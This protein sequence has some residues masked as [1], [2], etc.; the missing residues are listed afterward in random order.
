MSTDTDQ[1]SSSWLADSDKTVRY[2][3]NAEQDSRYKNQIILQLG[4]TGNQ[5]KASLY[6]KNKYQPDFSR[7][8]RLEPDGTLI[9][10]ETGN[11]INLKTL[12]TNFL[13]DDTRLII[14]GH[15]RKV[16]DQKTGSDKFVLTGK[17]VEQLADVLKRVTGGRFVHTISVLG[18]GTNAIGEHYPVEDFARKLF[19]EIRTKRITVRNAIVMVDGFGRKWTGTLPAEGN[20]LWSQSDHRVKLVLEKDEQGQLIARHP[21]VEEGLVKKLRNLPALPPFRDYMRLGIKDKDAFDQARNLLLNTLSEKDNR[22]PLSELIEQYNRRLQQL[23][24]D[25]FSP[26]RLM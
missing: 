18:C 9:D 26:Y 13:K 17:T 23:T 8:M 20:V 15:G 16:Q 1:Q 4:N 14:V 22:L 5:A 12:Q 11:N 21:P 10:P 2:A 19:G 25:D 6:L 7:L 3:L 24:G